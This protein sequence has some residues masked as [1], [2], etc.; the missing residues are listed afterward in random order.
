[1]NT[2]HLRFAMAALAT[3]WSAWSVAAAQDA[4]TTAPARTAGWRGDGTGRYPNADPPLHWSRISTSVKELSA[5]ARRPA[6]DAQPAQEAAIP[7][8]ILRRWL[9]LGPFP[10]AEGQKPDEALAD[11]QTLSPD[12]DD[13]AG[14]F[15]W[16]GPSETL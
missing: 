5:Q 11:A 9:V 16:R 15:T 3:A 6:T 14:G 1:M 7:D 13:R 4:S 12:K 2:H 8:G 10:R